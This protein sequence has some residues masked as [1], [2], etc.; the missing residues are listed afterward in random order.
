MI[1]IVVLLYKI[2]GSCS[3]KPTFP[4]SNV[5][6]KIQLLQMSQMNLYAVALGIFSIIYYSMGLLIAYQQYSI[7]ELQYFIK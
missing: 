3:A 5:Y 7:N 6:Y 1:C 2:I 4:L